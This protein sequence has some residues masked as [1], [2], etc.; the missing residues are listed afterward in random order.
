MQYLEFIRNIYN[1]QTASFVSF[2]HVDF[3][4]CDFFLIQITVKQIIIK[5]LKHASI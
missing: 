4:L 3:A 2:I 1:F 5:N